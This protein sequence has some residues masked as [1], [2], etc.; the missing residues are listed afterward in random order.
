PLFKQDCVDRE[1]CA[2]DSEYKGLLNSD[3]WRSHQIECKLCS[4]GHPYSKFMPGNIETLQQG[5]K[6]HGLNLYEELVK[7]YNKYYSSDIMKLVVYGNHSLDQLA[8]WAASKFSGIKSRGDNVQRDIGHPVSAEFLGKVI[9]FETIDDNHTMSMTFPVPDVRAMYRS[10]PFSY[11]SHLINHEGQGSI[12]AYLKRKGWA[13]G[14]GAGPNTSQN[15]GFCEFTVSISATPEGLEHYEDIVRTVFVYV[16]MLVSSG[17]QEWVQQEMSSMRRIKFDNKA[18]VDAL[19]WA[20]DYMHLIH[21]EYV[22]PEHVLSKDRAYE[23]FNYDDILHCLSFINPNNFRVFLSALKHESIDCSEI[24]PYFGAAYHVGCLS[25]DLLHELSSD[26]IH[27]DDLRLPERNQFMPTDFTIKNPNMLGDAA[28]LRPTLLRLNDNFELWFKQDDQ[29]STTKGNIYLSINVP[30]VGSSPLNRVMSLFYCSMLAS[31]L[32]EDL[33][34]AACAGLRFG[35]YSTSSTIEVS[36]AGFSSKLPELLKTVL[37]R[38]VS[39]KVDSTQFSVYMAKFKQ[40]YG[41][42]SNST[43]AELCGTYMNYISNSSTWHYK[44]VES[45]LPKITLDKLQAHVDSLFDVTFTKMCMVGNFDEADA[46][47][48]ADTVQDIIKP[49]PNLGYAFSR[50]R[51]YDF[52][53]GYY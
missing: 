17:P 9:H 10:D 13:V 14:L 18:K 25:A 2:V 6:D 51:T 35:A 39:F 29:F 37:E 45:E 46:L 16:Q 15:K 53:P 32:D 23:K 50:Q 20:L 36:V 40:A 44:L 47:K 5:A 43:P 7:F 48:V 4:P 24:E 27:V 49:T 12:L 8:E 33:C 22:A 11:I 30:T 42:V 31:D 26:S 52:E 38:V 28:V 41:N 19:N 3:F 34:N 1:L 21:N